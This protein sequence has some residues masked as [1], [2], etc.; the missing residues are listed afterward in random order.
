MKS[1]D[2]PSARYIDLNTYEP[3]S[4]DSQLSPHEPVGP[5]NSSPTGTISGAAIQRIFIWVLAALA[6]GTLFVWLGQ[7]AK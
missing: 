2:H 5:C 7:I 4:G 1:Y 6:V 3:L